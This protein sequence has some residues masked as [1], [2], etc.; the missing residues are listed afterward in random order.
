MPK[1]KPVVVQLTKEQ[2]LQKS[3]SFARE[4]N[5]MPSPTV[6]YEVGDMVQYGGFVTAKVLELIEDGK[7]YHLEC[8]D[9]KNI[10]DSRIANW[11]DV[12][13]TYDS[14]KDIEIHSK[15]DESRINFFQQDIQSLQHR[16]YGFGVDMNPEYQRELVWDENREHAL[17]DSIFNNIE[18]GK[19]AFI[20]LEF[21]G[22]PTAPCYEILDGK[23]RLNTIIKFTEGRIKYKGKTIFEMNGVD[24]HHFENYSI[25]VGEL[26]NATKK[27]VY[28]YFLKLNT[29]GITVPETH[30]NKVRDLYKSEVK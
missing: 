22:D 11:Y 30:L 13:K 19:F 5:F 4:A 14:L 21:K 24:R 1:K 28:E 9:H 26:R 18:I 25:S 20:H 6:F 17:L 2:Q 27:Q 8:V 29:G 16:Y 12:F 3:L 15:R 7:Y 10:V 23:Q